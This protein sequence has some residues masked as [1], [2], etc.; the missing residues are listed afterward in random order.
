MTGKAEAI[1]TTVFWFGGR[2][3]QCIDSVL[4]ECAQ[5]TIADLQHVVENV[6]FY[7]RLTFDDV[8]KAIRIHGVQNENGYNPN[9]S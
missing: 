8:I 6:Q 5:Q 3:K 4:A 7:D 9:C 1:S 2:P